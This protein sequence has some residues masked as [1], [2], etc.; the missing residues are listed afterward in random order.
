MKKIAIDLDGVVFDSE[1]LYRVYSE[2]YDTDILKSDNLID[3]SERTFQKRYNW[4]D[5]I[6]NTF[7]ETYT[8]HILESCNL[9]PG[10]DFILNKLKKD[11]DLVII[12]ARSDEELEIT[13]ERLKE[14]GLEYVKI[15][16]NQ[17]TKIETFIKEKVDIIIDDDLEICRSAAK[18]GFFS[19]Y[20]KNSFAPIVEEPNLKTVTTWGEI[21][22]YLVL[23]DFN[24]I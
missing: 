7:Y 18:Q 9:M 5:E 10:V 8:P 2:F 17:T 23:N 21:Y 13:K 16:Y 3:N 11:Y 19:L 22:K 14:V 1:T 20:F 4:N 24:T 15:H 6:C 12:T